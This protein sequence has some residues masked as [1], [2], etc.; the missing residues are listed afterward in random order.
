MVDRL[1]RETNRY[2]E[3]A[4]DA[5]VSAGKQKR[6][7]RS[8]KWKEVDREEMKRFL[9][10]LFLTG[11]VRKP[12]LDLYWS[13]DELLTTP[14]FPRSMPRN[15]FE[16]I[17]SYFHA[18]NNESRPADCEDRMYKVR[19]ILDGILEKFRD[20]YTPHENISIDEAMMFWRGRLSF[21]V[22]NPAKPHQIRN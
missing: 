17:W 10:L 3:Q 18:V 15:R 19:P 11:I 5:Q 9:G 12:D 4:I 16:L 1:V 21:R 22:Y 8:K 2:A 13:T 7:S 14:I 20:L 6:H